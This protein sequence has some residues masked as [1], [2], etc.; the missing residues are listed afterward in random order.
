MKLSKGEHSSELGVHAEITKE[1]QSEP[2]L[3]RAL[4]RVASLLVSGEAIEA[5]A[6]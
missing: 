1:V 5:T 2:G 4:E 3:V 6:T